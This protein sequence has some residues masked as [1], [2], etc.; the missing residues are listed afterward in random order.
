MEAG[1]DPITYEIVTPLAV[2]PYT[3]R[4]IAAPQGAVLG[5]IIMTS[6][7]PMTTVL[8]VYPWNG[9]PAD[10]PSWAYGA[11]AAHDTVQ[12]HS[13]R[14]TV[15]PAAPLRAFDA[16]IDSSSASTTV[17]VTVLEEDGAESRATFTAPVDASACS[18]YLAIWH[19]KG[20]QIRR[21]EFAPPANNEFVFGM[22]VRAAY[23]RH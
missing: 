15:G 20:G 9:C 7:S 3:Q 4:T 2:E 11:Y 6:T 19:K 12:L 14:G 16:M 8:R 1:F 17:T 21:V 23:Q 10:A 5:D 22:L 13:A 18:G